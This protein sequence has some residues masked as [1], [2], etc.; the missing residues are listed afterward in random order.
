MNIVLFT[1]GESPH[2]SQAKD[3]FRRLGHVSFTVAA[4]SG[5]DTLESYN[6]YSGLDVFRPDYIIGDMDSL[7]N[8]SLLEKHRFAKIVPYPCDKD[9]SDTELGLQICHSLKKSTSD[10]LVMVGGNGGRCDHF[11]SIYETFSMDIH[12]DIWLCGCQAVFYLPKD[13]SIS[14][15]G[16]GKDDCLSISRLPWDSFGGSVESEGLEWGSA[17]MRK[18]GMPSLSNR[19]CRSFYEKSMPVKLRAVGA[20]FLVFVPLWAWAE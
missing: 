6:T 5:L 14:V 8:K 7:K 4:D 13:G 16:L 2:P 17:L 9:F 20:S 10:R 18:K 1:G 15:Y 3:F 11:I 12:A 19:I